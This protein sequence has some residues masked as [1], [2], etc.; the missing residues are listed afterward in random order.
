MVAKWRVD[1]MK[2]ERRP[3]CSLPGIQKLPAGRIFVTP[4]ALRKITLEE[5]KSALVRHVRGDWRNTDPHAAGQV[6]DRD[7][8]EFRHLSFFRAKS[9][10]KFWVVT[11]L[12]RRMTT[13]EVSGDLS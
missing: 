2:E 11:T 10:T 5:I 4:D 3:I 12:D 6:V 9:G 8:D 13:V 1:P 7:G